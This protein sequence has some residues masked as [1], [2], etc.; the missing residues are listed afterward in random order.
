MRYADHPGRLARARQ[1]MSA[2]L[3]Y[4]QNIVNNRHHPTLYYDTKSLADRLG[5]SPDTIETW[6]YRGGG[7]PWIK[8]GKLIRYSVEAVEKWLA[9]QTR[10]PKPRPSRRQKGGV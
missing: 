9:E 1:M 7:P 6:R 10:A 5:L 8:I 2:T 3:C 4:M